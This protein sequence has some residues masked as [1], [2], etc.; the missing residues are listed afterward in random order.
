MFVTVATV[1]GSHDFSN[2]NLK[3][4]LEHVLFGYLCPSLGCI[5]SNMMFAGMYIT[6]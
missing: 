5:L 3:M 2:A 1:S 6:K 4:G